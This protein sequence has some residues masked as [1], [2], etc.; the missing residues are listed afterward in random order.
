MKKESITKLHKSFE[1]VAYQED[2]VEYWLARELQSLLDYTE[3][4]NFAQVIEKQRL[5]V[6]LPDSQ[7]LII[8]L[9]STKRY[10]CLKKHQKK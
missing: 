10:Q 2:G 8:L 9:T 4:R 7:F 6:K 3:W 1:E 5:L